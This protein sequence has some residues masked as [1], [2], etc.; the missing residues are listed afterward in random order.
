MRVSRLKERASYDW[1]VKGR[2]RCSGVSCTA[3]LS[4][5]Q[6]AIATFGCSTHLLNVLPLELVR[7]LKIE[8]P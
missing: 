4:K 5:H 3:D 2:I 7:S 8:R 1:R 6:C